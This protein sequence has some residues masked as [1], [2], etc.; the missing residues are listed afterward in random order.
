MKIL[1]STRA[2]AGGLALAALTAVGVGMSA[3]PANAASESTWDSLA[4]CES[5]GN[6]AIN[7]GNGFYGGLQFT[8][9][10]WHAFGGAGEPQYASKATQIAVAERVLA[11][12]GWNAW[13]A[14]SAKLGLT[15]S[16]NPTPIP[17]APAAPAVQSAPAAP[18]P[19]PVAKAAPAAPKAAAPA[20]HVSSVALS[21]KTYTVKSGD[22]LSKIA[23][24]LGV[25][26]GW[27]RLADAN[28][29]VVSNPN[30]IFPG[31]VLNLPR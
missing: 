15:D 13:P 10:T 2:A 4:Q 7:T 31:Q 17:A 5:S 22:T 29:S 14:C 8:L 19:A 27:E 30:L 16:A 3:A 18:A 20:R 9:S 24:R 6:W 11:S 21:G 26:G 12:Q 25:T 1:K 23:T 28:A